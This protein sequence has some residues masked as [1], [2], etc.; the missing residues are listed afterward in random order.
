MLDYDWP[1]PQATLVLRASVTLSSEKYTRTPIFGLKLFLSN[2]FE[3]Q[4]G[5][6]KFLKSHKLMMQ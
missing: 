1:Y 6:K 2:V 5:L 3:D 4:I